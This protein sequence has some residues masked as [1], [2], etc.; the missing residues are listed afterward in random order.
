MERAVAVAG[1]CVLKKKNLAKGLHSSVYFNAKPSDKP[2]E[3]KDCSE[4]TAPFGFAGSLVPP[5]QY[6]SHVFLNACRLE[7]RLRS[8]F[9][10]GGIIL[11]I[12]YRHHHHDHFLVSSGSCT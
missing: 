4:K 9:F 10:S 5:L 1:M 7:S 6:H 11:W 2:T 12:Y 3:K 8:I